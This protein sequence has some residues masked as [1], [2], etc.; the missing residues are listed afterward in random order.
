MLLAGIQVLKVH[1]NIQTV[2]ITSLALFKACIR[3]CQPEAV[4]DN[5]ANRHASAVA[6]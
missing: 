2:C 4:I 6:Q 3:T 5:L 1:S